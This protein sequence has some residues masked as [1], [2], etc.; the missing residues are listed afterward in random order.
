MS[1]FRLAL[2]GL[3]LGASA[4]TGCANEPYPDFAGSSAYHHQ[5]IQG[6]MLEQAVDY[7][8]PAPGAY[9]QQDSL[10][11]EPY[12]DTQTMMLEL[13]SSMRSLGYD[14]QP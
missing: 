12:Q 13:E 2:A 11:L 7:N 3:A 10:A 8:Q 9:G 1:F 6:A 4:L 5:A 14:D